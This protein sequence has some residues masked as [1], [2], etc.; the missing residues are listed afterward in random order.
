MLKRGRPLEQK[1]IWLRVG[2]DHM[3]LDRHDSAVPTIFNGS[4]SKLTFSLFP[5]RSNLSGRSP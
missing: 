2:M 3:Q 1:K 4:F 5:H